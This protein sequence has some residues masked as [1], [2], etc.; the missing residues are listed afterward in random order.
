MGDGPKWPWGSLTGV[1]YPDSG[2]Q[3]AQKSGFCSR[4]ICAIM[5]S[6]REFSAGTRNLGGKFKEKGPQTVIDYGGLGGTDLIP[7]CGRQV[8]RPRLPVRL[9][10]P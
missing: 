1:N 10:H 4:E 9:P 6:A 3:V 5:P 7:E 8:P 2:G